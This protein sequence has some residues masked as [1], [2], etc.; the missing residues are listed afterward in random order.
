MVRRFGSYHVVLIDS[1][2]GTDISRVAHLPQTPGAETEIG[3][4]IGDAL[5][6]PG[7]EVTHYRYH[8]SNGQSSGLWPCLYVGV[9]LL[10]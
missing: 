7:R 3:L 8:S 4:G 9:D 2:A 1:L 6:Y 5:L 10:D